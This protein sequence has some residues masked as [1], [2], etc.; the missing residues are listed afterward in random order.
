MVT[1]KGL[2][3]GDLVKHIYT[4][5]LGILLKTKLVDTVYDPIA[6]YPIYD[7]YVL[8][9]TDEARWVPIEHIRKI[10]AEETTY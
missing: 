8:F 5:E 3:Y 9:G 6:T 7:A 2:T 4:R 10:S 1:D